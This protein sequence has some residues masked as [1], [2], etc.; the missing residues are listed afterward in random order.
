VN[1]AEG[2][3]ISYSTEHRIYTVAVAQGSLRLF[4]AARYADELEAVIW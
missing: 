3:V 1:F 2:V 4:P